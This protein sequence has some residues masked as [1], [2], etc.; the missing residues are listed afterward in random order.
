[1][2]RGRPTTPLD[3]P[4][5]LPSSQ[6]KGANVSPKLLP[7][8]P[9]T[10]APN[11]TRSSGAIS[12]PQTFLPS[13]PFRLGALVNPHKA[14][15]LETS[16]RFIRPLNP[17]ESLHL[18]SHFPPRS[19]NIHTSLHQCLCH[20]STHMH[21]SPPTRE[22]LH[23][24]STLH[25]HPAPHAQFPRCAQTVTHMHTHRCKHTHVGT[26][27]L[28]KSPTHPRPGCLRRRRPGAERS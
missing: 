24:N 13:R 11:H 19:P 2:A 1:M 10:L 5:H 6:S 16:P 4:T 21:D 7:V 25:T 15:E 17:Q 27:K 28:P 26:S 23:T 20:T 3:P 8:R 12:T 14:T 9:P 18:R 22:P